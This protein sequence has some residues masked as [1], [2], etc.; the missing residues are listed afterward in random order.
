MP[1]PRHNLPYLVSGQAEGHVTHNTALNDLDAFVNALV[2]S[3]TA[4]DPTL[5]TP[6]NGDM[7]IVGPSSTGVWATHDG[8][9]ALYMSGWVFFDPPEGFIVRVKDEHGTYYVF[10]GTWKGVGIRDVAF[11]DHRNGGGSLTRYFAAGQNVQNCTALTT[12]AP[13]RD[14][15]HAMPF[16]VPQGGTIYEVGLNFTALSNLQFYNLGI[17]RATDE[18]NMYPAELVWDSGAIANPGATGV[19][20]QFPSQK[21]IWPGFL[22]WLVYN[23][24]ANTV[25]PTM[26]CLALAGTQALLGLDNTL[27]TAPGYGLQVA[28]THTGGGYTLP[29]TFPGSATAKTAVPI[30]G[31]FYRMG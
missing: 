19:Y 22:H 8:E 5:L 31:L 15:L 25:A 18:Q 29:T 9:L 14:T 2:E 7:Y 21:E 10:E 13:A 1:T 16:V 11:C 27:G 3:R 20:F 24:Q 23:C 4:T 30:P 12:G 26:R 28:H 6:A 17:Y